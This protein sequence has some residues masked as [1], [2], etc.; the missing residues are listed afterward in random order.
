LLVT[1]SAFFLAFGVAKLPSILGYLFLVTGSLSSVSAAV[2]GYIRARIYRQR[3]IQL[4]KMLRLLQN[5]S[6]KSINIF[7]QDLLNVALS[8]VPECDRGSIAIEESDGTW[9]FAAV[10]GYNEH[11]KDL[12]LDPS[13]L[14][15]VTA[16]VKEVER[17]WRYNQYMPEEIRRV[18]EA[19]GSKDIVRSIAVGIG[20]EEKIRGSFFLDATSD[21]RI[22]SNSKR[23]LHAFARLTS[24]LI[25]LRYSQEQELRY[26]KE[27]VKLLLSILEARDPYTHGHSDRVARLS[28]LT[29]R[30]LGLKEEEIN[31]AYWA[32]IFHDIGKLVVP[33][34]IL[35][36]PSELSSEEWEVIREHPVSGERFVRNFT[37]LNHL[38]PF[39]R[40]H[41]ERFD[42]TGY[43]DGLNGEKIPMISR[44]LAV[45][46]AFDAMVSD[47][48]YRPALGFE[49]AVKE[50]QR[51]A[52]LQFDPKVVEVFLEVNEV[53]TL[54][55]RIG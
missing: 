49:R 40:H 24:L 34:G 17:V 41:H 55:N 6:S 21:V 35:K 15:A 2:L 19:C 29:A 37:E 9:R 28:A 8:L 25:E 51:G 31:D 48:I 11:L 12:R 4:E 7:L 53:R 39:I 45:A 22:S 5:V 54:Y 16:E 38:A 1:L 46:D 50:L 26:R 13:H 14:Y 23:V 44:I 27:A 52:G 18:F 33:E 10:K 36:K 32:G 42:G 20:T 47:R 30:R 43:P 3:Y